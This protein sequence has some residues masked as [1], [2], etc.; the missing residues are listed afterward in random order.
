MEINYIDLYREWTD[1]KLLTEYG[2]ADDYQGSAVDAMETLLKERGLWAKVEEAEKMKQELAK[3]TIIDTQTEYE[4][5]KWGELTSDQKFAEHHKSKEGVYFD[6]VM[7][8]GG[9]QNL[10]GFT[11]A[12]A[13]TAVVFGVVF[14]ATEFQGPGV[15]LMCFVIA[16]LFVWWTVQVLRNNKV[17]FVLREEAGKPKAS[18]S[19][20][21]NQMTISSFEEY[22]CHSEWVEHYAKGVRIRRPNLYII[23]RSDDGKKVMLHEDKSALTSMPPGWPDVENDYDRIR[24][25][26]RFAQHGTT[27]IELEKLKKILDGL[28]T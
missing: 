21:A 27:R 3:A 4:K 24:S 20:G 9:K 16:A 18:I 19:W 2:K 15:I 22:S 10:V 14:A 1:E 12:M 8:T 17:Q 11:G 5:E 28:T 7:M 6:K 13:I 23:L 25:D 26:I